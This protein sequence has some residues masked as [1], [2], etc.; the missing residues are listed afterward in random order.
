MNSVTTLPEPGYRSVLERAV[1]DQNFDIER[2]ER[3]VAMQEAFEQRQAVT[4]YNESLAAAQGEMGTVSKDSANP[5]TRSRYA[6]LGA[7]D[8][9]LRGIWT[10]HG[11]GI[12]FNEE[13]SGDPGVMRCVA[14][15]SKGPE[16]RRFQWDAP[17]S[18]R[19]LQGRVMMTDMHAKAA[20]TSYGRRNLLLMIWNIATDDDDGNMGQTQT[21]RDPRDE[22]S[23]PPPRQE[24][25]EV[26]PPIDPETGEVSPHLIQRVVDQD[27]HDE[28]WQEWG[29]RFFAGIRASSTVAELDQ[30]WELNKPHLDAFAK[31]LPDMFKR[32]QGSTV[33]ER[34]KF[35]TEGAS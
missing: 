8:K 20:A 17:I 6:S 29:A 32:L 19:G 21:Q 5:Q 28:P 31:D 27:G 9:A 16:T 33:R 3:I 2:L 23:G 7:L 15:V 24:R 30:W 1:T 34:G 11:F 22:R 4:A 35:T 18:S 13:P 14:F 12:Q 25:K 10:R 26:E